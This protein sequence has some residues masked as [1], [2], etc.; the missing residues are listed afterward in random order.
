MNNKEIVEWSEGVISQLNKKA[1]LK[2]DE[3]IFLA[4]S[5]YRKFLIP[6]ISNYKIPLEGLG[7][8]KQLKYLKEK[9]ENEQ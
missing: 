7:I 3:F 5:K 9:T 2:K 8:G 6:H 4:G 1:D